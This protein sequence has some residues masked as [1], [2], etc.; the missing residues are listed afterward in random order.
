MSAANEAPGS[1]VALADDRPR[2]LAVMPLTAEPLLLWVHPDDDLPIAPPHAIRITACTVETWLAEGLPP[3]VLA[4]RGRGVA[5]ACADAAHAGVHERVVRLREQVAPRDAE[6]LWHFADEAQ[7]H[8]VAAAL[9]MLPPTSTPGFSEL[10][11]AIAAQTDP[12]AARL[13]RLSMALEHL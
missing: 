9:S 12:S 5:V 4:L 11:R 8:A 10:A 1:P 13:A 2:A 7:L 3:W 6:A